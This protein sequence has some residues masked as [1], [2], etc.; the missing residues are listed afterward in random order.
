[1]ESGLSEFMKTVQNL[2]LA[3]IAEK[4]EK[5]LDG[6]EKLVTS[7]DIKETL[8]SIHQTV[9]EAHVFLRN[10][11]SQ[12]KPL[13]TST[14]LTLSEA[15]K[16]FR[17]G[18]QL[19]RN[20]DS[21]IPSLIASLEDTSKAAGLTMKEANNAVDRFAGANSAVRL[22]LIKTLSEFSDAARSVRILAQYLE[23]HPEAL[24]KGKGN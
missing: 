21:R 11:D 17:D 12:V 10:L 15:K 7:P 16:L 14:Q 19:A 9:D 8:V 2:P 22:E 13:A 23:N 3:A 6:M 24:I 18:G 1:V 20:L 4:V 5:T